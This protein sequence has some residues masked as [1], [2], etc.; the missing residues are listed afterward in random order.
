MADLWGPYAR[1]RARQQNAARKRD[2]APKYCP[3]C[4]TVKR[5]RDFYD[6]RDAPNGKR[7]TCIV[8]D[9]KRDARNYLKRKAAKG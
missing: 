9:R 2:D 3:T 4:E 6:N 5:R 1:E 7:S 8:C